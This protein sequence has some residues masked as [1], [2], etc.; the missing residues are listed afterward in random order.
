VSTFVPVRVPCE[1]CGTVTER[2]LATSINVDRTPAWRDV[3]LAGDFQRYRCPACGAESVAVI[4]FPYID[5]TRKLYVGVFPASMEAAWWDHEWEP[6][7]AFDRNL[8]DQAP[9]LARPIGAGMAVRTVFGLD[10][11]REKIIGFEQGLDDA[12]LETLKLRLMAGRDDVPRTMSSRPR[13]T[14]VADGMLHFVVVVPAG[15]ERDV[16]TL[17][18]AMADYESIAEEPDLAA[19]LDRLRQGPYCDA[20]RLL[21]PSAA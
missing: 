5:F 10:A 21:R 12:Q 2:Q 8:G 15:D 13:L 14:S 1:R 6:A 4:P 18:V 19:F 20:G 16:Y 7:A 9:A 3:I 17:D 11:L